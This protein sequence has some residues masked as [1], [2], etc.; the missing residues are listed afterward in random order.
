MRQEEFKDALYDF[1][2]DL[3]DVE[4]AEREIA[5]VER[6]I[7]KLPSGKKVRSRIVLE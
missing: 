6:L 2:W 3:R 4:G 7:R 5:S 1:L